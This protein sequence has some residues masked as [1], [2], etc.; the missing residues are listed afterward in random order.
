MESA[1]GTEIEREELLSSKGRYHTEY[2][3]DCGIQGHLPF[4]LLENL[5]YAI[6]VKEIKCENGSVFDLHRVGRN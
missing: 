5:P 1:A 3:V 6:K 4:S 2:N